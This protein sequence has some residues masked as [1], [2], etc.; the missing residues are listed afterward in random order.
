MRDRWRQSRPVNNGDFRVAV[1][2]ERLDAG[3]GRADIFFQD[4]PVAVLQYQIT[5]PMDDPQRPAN[6]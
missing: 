5:L 6:R 3:F 4:I 2:D 1:V